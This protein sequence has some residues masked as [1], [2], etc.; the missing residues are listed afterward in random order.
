[1]LS[2]YY[3]KVYNYIKE[4]DSEKTA[5]VFS[6]LL[7]DYKLPL[8]IY[9]SLPGQPFFLA[10]D[11]TAAKKLDSDNFKTHYAKNLTS[12]NHTS[13]L[14][15]GA[16]RYKHKYLTGEFYKLSG[17]SLKEFKNRYLTIN[18]LSL[19]KLNAAWVLDWKASL[20]Y[21]AEGRNGL[22]PAD[23]AYH[24]VFTEYDIQASAAKVFGGKREVVLPSRKRIDIVDSWVVTEV[25]EGLA[26]SR[27]LGQLFEYLHETGIKKGRLIGYEFSHDVTVLATILK[28]NGFEIELKQYKVE[29]KESTE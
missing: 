6:T 3:A 12:I 1:M 5:I 11:L 14:G 24:I 8:V 25:K 26:S 17:G 16:L 21:L 22:L 13:Y 2:F 27:H 23:S 15:V 7:K 20:S 28:E 10:V 19:G 18:K 29:K 4:A 9:D